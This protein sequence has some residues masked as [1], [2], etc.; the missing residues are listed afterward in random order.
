MDATIKFTP[1][2]ILRNTKAPQYF[3][4]LNFYRLARWAPRVSR[5]IEKVTC[6]STG[7]N[8][9]MLDCL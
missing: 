6:T 5:F 1:L 7:N 8:M 4:A 3:D 2:H 9:A